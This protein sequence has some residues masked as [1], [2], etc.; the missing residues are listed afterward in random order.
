[1][2]QN[3]WNM[4]YKNNL[5]YKQPLNKLWISP[6]A[7]SLN[8]SLCHALHHFKQVDILTRWTKHIIIY[9]TTT[10]SDLLRKIVYMTYMT[11]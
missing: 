4:N 9:E 8:N 2:L 6:A 11:T 5:N 10:Y 3:N 7:Y 1:M